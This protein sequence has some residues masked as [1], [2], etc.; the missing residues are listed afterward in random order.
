MSDCNQIMQ[1]VGCNK[2]P[3]F[4]AD[5]T[6]EMRAWYREQALKYKHLYP[7][8]LQNGWWGYKEHCARCYSAIKKPV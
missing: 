2:M 5:K 6:P 4:L 7:C 3:Q 8:P 1:V